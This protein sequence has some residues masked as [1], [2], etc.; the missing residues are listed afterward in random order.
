MF[1][2]WN[3]RY[4]IYV[5]KQKKIGDK[6]KYV[7]KDGKK[8]PFSKGILA[9]SISSSGITTEEA[10]EIV[11][12]IRSE[13]EDKGIQELESSELKEYVSR[14]MKER[15]YDM[16]ERYYRVRRKIKYLD[17]PLFIL[18]GGGPGVGKSTLSA[19]IGH[20]LGIRRVIGSDTVREIM[21]S[22]ISP[23][24][25]PT[26]HE[27]TFRACDALRTPYVDNKLIYAFEQQ[28]SLVSQGMISVMKRGKKEGLNI[29]L[30]G[31][32]IVP[33]F[34]EKNIDESECHVFQYILDVP[35]VS[36]HKQHFY[37]REEG[38]KRDPERYIEMMERIRDIQDYVLDMADRYDVDI[39]KNKRYEDTLRII[40]DDI[41]DRL[42]KEMEI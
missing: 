15:G 32:H 1:P 39:V 27:S 31:V 29:V 12:K 24:L 37:S 34:I 23:E 41:I 18:I 11:R 3:A 17:K 4:K 33:G 26:L 10:Y 22:I 13:L 40:L 19:E 38:S 35:D 28:V 16:E 30:N 8:F 7:I 36:Q 20:R 2:R 9:R 25:I 21:R 6:L 14:E 42:E 5:K